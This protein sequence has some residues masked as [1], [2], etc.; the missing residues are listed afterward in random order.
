M[1]TGI[2]H[3]SQF[4]NNVQL[5]GSMYVTW[6]GMNVIAEHRSH[7]TAS[8][9]VYLDFVTMLLRFPQVLHVAWSRSFCA[10]SVALSLQPTLQT[11]SVSFVFLLRVWHPLQPAKPTQTEIEVSLPL[12]AV[13]AI[14]RSHDEGGA[15]VQLLMR[16]PA[17]HRTREQRIRAVFSSTFILSCYGERLPSNMCQRLTICPFIDQLGC[18][19]SGPALGAACR[20]A[21][22]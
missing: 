19:V 15:P 11:G 2:A 3:Q 21:G 13:W 20:S 18:I 5:C 9:P 10:N 6:H 1:D 7:S 14:P 8:L 22:V 16:F 4:L 12:A 17:S